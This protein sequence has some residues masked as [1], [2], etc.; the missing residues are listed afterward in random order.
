MVLEFSN[1]IE[2]FF[3]LLTKVGTRPY[4]NLSLSTQTGSRHWGVFNLSS[5]EYEISS[6]KTVHH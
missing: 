6:F 4:L 1:P 2:F 3:S 5:P